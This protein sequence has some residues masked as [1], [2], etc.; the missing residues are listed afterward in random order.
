MPLADLRDRLH[1]FL[2]GAGLRTAAGPEKVAIPLDAPT[3]RTVGVPVG[4]A[5]GLVHPATG[6]SVAASLQAGGTIADAVLAGADAAVLRALVRS[7][8][9]RA[10]S[11]LLGVGREVLIGLDEA[12][13]DTFFSAFFTDRKSVV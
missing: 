1:R 12:Q 9:Q 13:T 2:D 6:Y 11:G 7:A 5:A 4:A 3:R 10:T 8:R